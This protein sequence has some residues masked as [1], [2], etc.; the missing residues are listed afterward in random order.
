MLFLLNAFPF[1]LGRTDGPDAGH[2]PRTDE[3][4]EAVLLMW[5]YA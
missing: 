4:A 3:E 5:W 1:A 2:E